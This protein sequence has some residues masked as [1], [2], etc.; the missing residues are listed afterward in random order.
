MRNAQWL[1][2]VTLGV[3][4]SVVGGMAEADTGFAPPATPAHPVTDVIHGVKLTDAY[5]WL[6]D[7]HD[8]QVQAWTRAQHEA[9]LRY[10]DET[11]PPIAG[12]HEELVAYFDRDVT[13]P[14]FFK[15]DREFFLRTR[16]GE[17]QAKLYTKLEGRDVLLFDPVALDPS[18]KTA[19][20]SV[21]P[22][23]DGS[24]AAVWMSKSDASCHS[25]KW[26]CV[27]APRAI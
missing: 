27:R 11:A 13:R 9:T 2:M 10:L 26:K 3:A 12:L 17:P 6:E 24:H 5:R 23:R 7:G 25:A 20:G 8:P 15:R 22:N 16:K 21:V 19:I 4:L 18:G 14:P 1:A